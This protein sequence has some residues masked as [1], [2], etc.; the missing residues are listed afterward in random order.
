MDN[1]Q[2]KLE[3][4]NRENEINLK[5]NRIDVDSPVLQPPEDIGGKVK[6]VHDALNK[7]PPPDEFRQI[8]GISGTCPAVNYQA[9]SGIQVSHKVD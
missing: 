5:E 7:F 2:K 8:V 1:L 9:D 4:A 6:V 3:N